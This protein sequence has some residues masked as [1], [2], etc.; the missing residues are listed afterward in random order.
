MGTQIGHYS[1][2]IASLHSQVTQNL[3][4]CNPVATYII[5]LF[6][7]HSRVHILYFQ[8]CPIGSYTLGVDTQHYLL[9]YMKAL[10]QC[11]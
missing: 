5:F 6:H 10:S 2:Q 11:A 4:A 9:Y 1:H 3:N 7:L 8:V